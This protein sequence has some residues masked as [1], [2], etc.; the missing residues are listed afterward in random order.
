MFVVV[1]LNFVAVR[2]PFRK[3]VSGCIQSTCFCH[4]NH[5]FV[6][7]NEHAHSTTLD[8]KL[9]VWVVSGNFVAAHHPIR[10]QVSGSIKARV[11]ATR[12]ISSFFTTNMPNPLL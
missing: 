1:S 9:M 5:F 6:F 2:H 3:P 8:P 4:R 11:F 12:T 7:R 10:K